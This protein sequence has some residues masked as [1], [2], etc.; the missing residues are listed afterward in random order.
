MRISRSLLPVLLLLACPAFLA[1]QRPLGGPIRV[2]P[3]AQDFAVQPHL[4]T[5]PAGEFVVTWFG[6][7][8]L[9]YECDALRPPLRGGR[10]TRDRSDPGLGQPQVRLFDGRADRRRDAGGRL[11][12]RGVPGGFRERLR[13]PSGG[14][15]VRGRRH[16]PEG[17]R[18][19]QRPG[20]APLDRHPG[21]GGV[22]LAWQVVEAIRT[23][24][25]GPDLTPLGPAVMI[26]RT[27]LSPRSRRRPAGG[28]SWPG[29]AS[30]RNPALPCPTGPSS[31]YS[32][33]PPTD[34]RWERP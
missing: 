28:S 11:V 8:P 22:A 18:G 32:A 24:S 17:R 26:S 2:D 3:P 12:R 20:G 34:R 13:Q 4:A 15:L 19:D 33:S 1:A 30:L 25:F 10:P 6:F 16:P 31:A 5:N 23:R 7:P 27:G 21:D 14:S 9:L 29:R